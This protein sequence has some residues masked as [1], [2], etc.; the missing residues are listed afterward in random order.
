MTTAKKI[1]YGERS[2][3][4]MAYYDKAIQ[5]LSAAFHYEAVPPDADNPLSE[6]VSAAERETA[7][8]VR[9]IFE[10]VY[11]PG[12]VQKTAARLALES[13]VDPQ[14]DYP[15]PQTIIAS[16][17]IPVLTL[18]DFSAVVGQAGTRKSWFCLLLAGCYLSGGRYP[19][20][21]PFELEA[22][23]GLLIWIDTE[24]GAS[25]VARTQRRLQRMIGDSEGQYMF[26]S[27]REFDAPTRLMATAYLIVRYKPTMVIIDGIA[28]LM[29]DP[30]DVLE[31]AVIRQ[32]LLSAS[33]IYGNHIVTVIHSNE[34]GITDKAR[35]HVGSEVAR[36]AA[37]MFQLV[38]EGDYTNVTYGKTR[39]ACPQ[40][41]SL[42]IS[43]G[44]PLT[45]AT[46]TPQ[47]QASKEKLNVFADYCKAHCGG[48][49]HVDLLRHF[50][51][52][53]GKSMVTAKRLCKLATEVE[54]IEK[55]GDLYYAKT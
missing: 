51:D 2:N 7:D 8:Y 28:D 37:T 11:K 4:Q 20:N 38:S 46:V 10:S 52:A 18:G 42:V 47:T 41:F 14:K 39:D 33:S 25:R 35:G 24:Q 29:N 12:S 40:T 3:R 9:S 31:S 17:G 19:A 26:F 44:M 13:Y 6:A 5:R 34:K 49:R 53:T 27:M 21:S 43:D 15:E 55:Q 45:T 50:V 54:L 48:V 36:K 16:D 1:P 23:P 32:F 22:P 30:N